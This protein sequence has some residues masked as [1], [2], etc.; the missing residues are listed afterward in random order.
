[1]DS[2][3]IKRLRIIGKVIHFYR[4]PGVA[5]VRCVECITQG[6]RIRFLGSHTDFSESV[7]S[8]ECDHQPITETKSGQ[9][10]G[11]KVENRVREGDWVLAGD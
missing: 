5:I 2:G 4:H 1:M 8:M 7:V 9:E 10:V 11:I 6:S 3:S